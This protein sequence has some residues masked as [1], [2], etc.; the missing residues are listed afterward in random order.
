MGYLA[1]SHEEEYTAA[2]D[3]YIDSGLNDDLPLPP[4]PKP[5]ERERE[6]EAQLHNPMSVY[7]WL[8]KNRSDV[9]IDQ[10]LD[11]QASTTNNTSTTKEKSSKNKEKDKDNNISSSTGGGSGGR[12]PSPRTPAVPTR[13]TDRKRSAVKPDLLIDEVLDEDGF[14]IGGTGLSD[15]VDG[16]RKRKRGKEDEPYRPK[17]GSSRP[18]KRKRASTGTRAEKRAEMMDED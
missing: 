9:F 5:T 10:P 18:S 3:T 2:L 12:K 15:A 8:A 6:R 4:R 1:P 17:G 7:N 14:V 16:G 11:E 13:T